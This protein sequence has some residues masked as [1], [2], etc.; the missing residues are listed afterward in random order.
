MLVHAGRRWGGCGPCDPFAVQRFVPVEH[1]LPI[2]FQIFAEIGFVPVVYLLDFGEVASGFVRVDTVCQREYAV[3]VTAE[4]Q[5]DDAVA[6]EVGQGSQ[7]AVHGSQDGFVAFLGISLFASVSWMS[8][9]WL[10]R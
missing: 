3:V 7:G 6:V 2:R 4:N 8:P 10:R 1:F 5:V 9:F